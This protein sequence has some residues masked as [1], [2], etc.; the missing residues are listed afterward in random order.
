MWSL[1]TQLTDFSETWHRYSAYEWSV[2]RFT[3]SEV[4][5]QDRDVLSWWRRT[6]YV[7]C[8]LTCYA[9][10]SSCSNWWESYE[11]LSVFMFSCCCEYC[12]HFCSTWRSS[13]LELSTQNYSAVSLHKATAVRIL[14]ICKCE[15]YLKKLHQINSSCP[16]HHFLVPRVT[17]WCTGH[18][19]SRTVKAPA[20]FTV[21]STDVDKAGT[22]LTGRL[23]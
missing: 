5:G 14:I 7:T 12:K 2:L 20:A 21:C 22:V 6:F 15:H 3:R 1:C 8:C 11:N 13:H 18:T 16:I 9:K 19:Y 17:Q 23:Y 10:N 4:K